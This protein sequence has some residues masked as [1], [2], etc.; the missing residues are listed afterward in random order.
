M[1][2]P[3]IYWV[4]FPFSAGFWSLIGF[5]HL[6]KPRGPDQESIIKK[7]RILTLPLFWYAATMIMALQNHRIIF[8]ASFPVTLLAG[9]GVVETCK[10]ILS[11]QIDKDLAR[12]QN[13]LS[14]K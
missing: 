11:K 1:E 13:K 14:S 5:Y 2:A 3:V 4:T 9:Y 10:Y 7:N 8:L 12:W 6:V